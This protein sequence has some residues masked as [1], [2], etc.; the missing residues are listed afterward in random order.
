MLKSPHYLK[1]A[2]KNPN[3]GVAMTFQRD[4]ESGSIS[5]YNLRE[6]YTHKDNDFHDEC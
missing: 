1:M 3:T 5:G 4:H 2:N 6:T